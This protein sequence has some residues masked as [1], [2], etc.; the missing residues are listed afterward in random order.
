MGYKLSNTIGNKVLEITNT[1][2][3]IAYIVWE[4]NAAFQ[5]EVSK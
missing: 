3:C 4:E 5:L 1:V 2:W